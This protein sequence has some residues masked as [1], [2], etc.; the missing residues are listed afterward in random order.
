MSVGHDVHV[1]QVVYVPPENKWP[2]QSAWTSL[3]GLG[4]IR[5][6]A[7]PY[8]FGCDCSAFCP[9]FQACAKFVENELDD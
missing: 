5:A 2:T 3:L 6:R 4:K 9:F 1:G 8:R 7:W